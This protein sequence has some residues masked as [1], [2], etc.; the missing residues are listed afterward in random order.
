M[1]NFSKL[2]NKFNFYECK[3]T[4]KITFVSIPHECGRD[5]NKN[6]M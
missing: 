5:E 6:C 1:T 3:I 2:S 4:S